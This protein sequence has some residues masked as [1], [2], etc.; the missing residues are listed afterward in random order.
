MLFSWK[1]A[2]IYSLMCY[3]QNGLSYVQKLYYSGDGRN[4]NWA[5]IQFSVAVSSLCPDSSRSRHCTTRVSKLNMRATK[6]ESPGCLFAQPL[7]PTIAS[8][9]QN[10]LV[11]HS[12][13]CLGLAYKYLNQREALHLWCELIKLIRLSPAWLLQLQMWREPN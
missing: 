5:L 12:L 7:S 8:L 4:K 2:N 1:R 3:Q 11:N 6:E 13:V 9:E 10:E